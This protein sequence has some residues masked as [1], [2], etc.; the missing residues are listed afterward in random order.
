MLSMA[1]LESLL[2]QRDGQ[3]RSMR[4]RRNRLV[5][6]L[7]KLDR[8]LA[9]M[10]GEKGAVV[11]VTASPAKGD[12]RR[13]RGRKGG[14]T[15][16]AVVAEILAAAGEP[17]RLKDIAVAAQAA[18]YKSA[19]KDFYNVVSQTLRN[20]KSFKCVSRGAYALAGAAP[21]KAK[22]KAGRPKKPRQAKPAPPKVEQAS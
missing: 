12:G 6:E 22:K 14:A 7:A 11:G 1:R 15:L 2:R 18:G 20:N 3:I 8:Q 17:M 9:A 19:S 21:A 16:S 10:T 5:A 13:R 4:E